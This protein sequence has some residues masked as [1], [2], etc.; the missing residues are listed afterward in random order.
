M[1]ERYTLDRDGVWISKRTG[2]PMATPDRGYIPMPRIMRD[3][4]YK[5]PL[6]GLPVTSRSQRREEMK[7]HGVREVDPGEFTP[8]YRDKANAVANRGEHQ[9]L[10]RPKDEAPFVRLGKDALPQRLAKTVA[11]TL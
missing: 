9:A 1:T 8:V 5:S 10:E 6:S 2:L 11:K 7:I 4:A 3:V